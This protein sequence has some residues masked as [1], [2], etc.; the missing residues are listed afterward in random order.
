MIK[1][2]IVDDHPVVRNGLINIV[3]EEKDF[4]LCGEASNTNK[5]FSKLKKTETDIILLDISMPGLNGYDALPKLKTLFP[6]IPVIMLSALSEEIYAGQC[7]KSGASGF[8]SKE[9]SPEELPKAIRK[10][11]NGGLYISNLFAEKLALSV[12]KNFGNK[13]HEALSEREFQVL[14]MLGEGK[15]LKQVSQSLNLSP[16]TISTYRARILEKMNLKNNNE[17]IKYCIQFGFIQ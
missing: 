17:I 10:V 16:K 13:A 6:R 5:M 1:I 4:V 2:F 11:F 12:S 9:A 14:I 3:S 7:L 15:T 8:I